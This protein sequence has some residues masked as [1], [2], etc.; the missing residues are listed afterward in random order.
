M[1]RLLC[2]LGIHTRPKTVPSCRVLHFA[3]TKE[4][5]Q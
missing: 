1:R 3:F 4:R 5:P 2:W